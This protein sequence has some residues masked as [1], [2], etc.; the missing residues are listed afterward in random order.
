MLQAGHKKAEA[1]LAA[2]A[3]RVNDAMAVVREVS[4]LGYAELNF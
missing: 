3:K 1:E 2:A 4:R